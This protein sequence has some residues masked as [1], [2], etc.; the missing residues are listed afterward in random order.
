[1]SARLLKSGDPAPKLTINTEKCAYI[2]QAFDSLAKGF[3]P[4]CE[5]I[6]V[7]RV[8]RY[9]DSNVPMKNEEI[10]RVIVELFFCLGYS[11][12]I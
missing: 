11:S 9:V 4:D 10:F 5:K 7:I 1:M 8:A 3:I 12:D 6:P 2:T